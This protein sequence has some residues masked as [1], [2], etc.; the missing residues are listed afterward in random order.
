MRPLT[1][2]S[3]VHKVTLVHAHDGSP[4]MYC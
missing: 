1:L 4:V 3:L 2:N